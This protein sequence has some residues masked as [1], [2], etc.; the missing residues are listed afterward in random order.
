MG[1]DIVLNK[2]GHR[3]LSKAIKEKMEKL[4]ITGESARYLVAIDHGWKPRV[5]KEKPINW[6]AIWY[7][8]EKYETVVETPRGTTGG[9][10]RFI[11]VPVA[12]TEERFSEIEMRYKV[13]SVVGMDVQDVPVFCWEEASDMVDQ[14][15]DYLGKPVIFRGCRVRKNIRGEFV[16]DSKSFF[17]IQ[18]PAED[19]LTNAYAIYKRR[20]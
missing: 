2:I 17:K 3:E 9:Y 19:Q 7:L 1:I 16:V 10:C 8:E 6:L 18:F 13:V 5:P 11:A 20:R 4:G 12:V 14:L 15:E